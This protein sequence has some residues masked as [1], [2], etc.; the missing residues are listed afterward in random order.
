MAQQIFNIYC[1]ESC[2]LENDK[3]PIMVL[4]AVWCAADKV[5]AI[6]QNLGQIKEKH[7]LPQAFEV[8]WTKVGRHKK[9]FYLEWLDYFFN[10]TDLHF[11][12]LIAPKANLNHEKYSQ[13]HD[14]W[15][16]KMYFNMLKVL[17][18]PDDKYHIYIDIKDSR[19]GRKI[20]KLHEVLC[21]NRYDF[22][23]SI[24]ERVQI[25]RSHE[26]EILQLADLLIGIISYTNRELEGNVGKESMVKRAKELSKYSL[27]K[28]TLLR[29]NKVN[30]FKWM[31][32]GTDQ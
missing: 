29:E 18:N 21:N 2:H 17:F 3:K 10:N 7:G 30:L 25:I 14:E 16:Y 22:S 1:D 23:R 11:R 28:T 8:K 19:G 32:A 20:R 5:R 9:E 6:S 15:Y 24:I 4:G 31:P 26:S 12:A 27:L 13:N